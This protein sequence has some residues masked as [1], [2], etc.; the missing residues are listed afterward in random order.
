MAS[1]STNPPEIAKRDTRDTILL[2]LRVEALEFDSDEEDYMIKFISPKDLGPLQLSFVTNSLEG[3][4]EHFPNTSHPH[5]YVSKS[6][7]FFDMFIDL[8]SFNIIGEVRDMAAF[9][10]ILGKIKD[11]EGK[12]ES[13]ADWIAQAVADIK[14]T[15]VSRKESGLGPVCTDCDSDEWNPKHM[16]LRLNLGTDEPMRVDYSDIGP[17]DSGTTVKVGGAD[18]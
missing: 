12:M 14:A 17:K 13:S 11:E 3:M 10:E 6:I 7:S 1:T 4:M 2:Y 8:V 18:A 16:S 9:E 5:E 15:N